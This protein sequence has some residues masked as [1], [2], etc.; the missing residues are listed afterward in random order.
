MKK[1]KFDLRYIVPIILGLTA[2]TILVL[3]IIFG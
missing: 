1:P 3:I 2:V